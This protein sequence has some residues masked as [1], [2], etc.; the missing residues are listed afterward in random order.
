[1]CVCLYPYSLLF[2]GWVYLY[3]HCFFLD[4]LYHF[5]FLFGFCVIPSL[6]GPVRMQILHVCFFCGCVN[7]CL[8]GGWFGGGDDHHHEKEGGLVCPFVKGGKYEPRNERQKKILII[9]LRQTELAVY[10]YLFY[11]RGRS[12]IV[13]PNRDIAASSS[14]KNLS[15]TYLTHDNNHSPYPKYENTVVGCTNSTFGVSNIFFLLHG[16]KQREHLLPSSTSVLAHFDRL[17]VELLLFRLRTRTGPFMVNRKVPNRPNNINIC[18]HYLR[19]L[20]LSPEI[21]S[22][23]SSS[24]D[25]TSRSQIPIAGASSA[26]KCSS[27]TSHHN[28]PTV[29]SDSHSSTARQDSLFQCRPI[30]PTSRPIKDTDPSSSNPSLSPFINKSSYFF[31]SQFITNHLLRPLWSLYRQGGRTKV[32]KGKFHWCQ[33]ECGRGN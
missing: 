33:R 7:G 16:P 20:H 4:C 2:F 11:R 27:S 13:Q 21:S 8:L 6:F 3:V 22:S 26:I 10:I 15:F 5:L 1:M 29:K 17:R 32:N 9:P 25:Q 24:G 12:R 19:Y 14:W 31:Y 28:Q 18:L 23:E 30:H